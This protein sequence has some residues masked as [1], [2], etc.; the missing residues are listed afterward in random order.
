[1]RMA[2]GVSIYVTPQSGAVKAKILPLTERAQRAFS[3][4]K[5]KD[6]ASSM[7]NNCNSTLKAWSTSTDAYKRSALSPGTSALKNVAALLF[8]G[9]F[10]FETASTPLKG[11]P[12]S[13]S[14]QLN[15]PDN[16]STMA[17]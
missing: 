4:G 9:N 3:K 12:A 5:V 17:M 1:M 2:T 16:K 14:L 15:L 6:M 7:A 10:D 11:N 13:Y 8:A